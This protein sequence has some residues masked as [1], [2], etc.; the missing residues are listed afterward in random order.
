MKQFDC[1][2]SCTWWCPHRPRSPYARDV[3]ESVCRCCSCDWNRNRE[4]W[5]KDLT[6]SCLQM[7]S[8]LFQYFMPSPKFASHMKIQSL[9]VQI[10]SDKNSSSKNYLLSLFSISSIY[11]VLC[12]FKLI[13]SKKRPAIPLTV[14]HDLDSC[15][16]S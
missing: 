3:A 16:F 4:I 11:L 15:P 9:K 6:R 14:S 8:S 2:C 12:I 5:I 10:S 7:H 1:Y 13:N